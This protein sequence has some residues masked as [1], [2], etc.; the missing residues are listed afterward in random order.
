MMFIHQETSI[1]LQAHLI[2][3]ERCKQPYTGCSGM[4]VQ[5]FLLTKLARRL[6][7]TQDMWQNSDMIGTF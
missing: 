1:Q 4:I 7:V 5:K 2:S 3:D 6:P